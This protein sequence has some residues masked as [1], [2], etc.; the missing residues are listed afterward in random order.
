[1]HN[2]NNYIANILLLHVFHCGI[3][4]LSLSPFELIIISVR[5]VA[6]KPKVHFFGSRS[7]RIFTQNSTSECDG[8]C[9]CDEDYGAIVH[10]YFRAVYSKKIPSSYFSKK[11]LLDLLEKQISLLDIRRGTSTAARW[12]GRMLGFFKHPFLEQKIERNNRV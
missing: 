6:T 5:T 9:K 4:P 2:Y 10:L 8:K 3:I 1:M 11:S 12:E 7:Q